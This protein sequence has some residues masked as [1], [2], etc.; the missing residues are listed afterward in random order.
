MDRNEAEQTWERLVRESGPLTYARHLDDEAFS[1]AIQ[2]QRTVL[3]EVWRDGYGSGSVYITLVVDRGVFA[4]AMHRQQ[5]SHLY[6][7][8]TVVFAR[9]LHLT[10]AER[11]RLAGGGVD[12]ENWSEILHLPDH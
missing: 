6:S 4:L 7:W 1:R 8:K 2:E 11:A 5:H 9:P 10:N 3:I 12:W